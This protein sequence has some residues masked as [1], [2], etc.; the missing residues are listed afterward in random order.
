MARPAAGP[1]FAAMFQSLPSPYMVLDRDLR[2]VAANAAYCAVTERAVE[3]LIGAQ[4][5][6][7]FPNP[8][9][10]G[11]RLRASFE[12]VLRTGKPHSIPLIPYP[13]PLPL[14]RGGGYEM[15]YWSA[16]HTPLLDAEGRTEFIV[17]NTVDVTD[18]QRLK[19]M[20]YG[21]EGEIGPAETTLLQRTREAEAA[22][23]TLREETAGL[24]E[25]FMQAPGFMAVLTGADL[26]FSLVNNAY[27]QLIGHR[28]VIGKPLLSALPEIR[29]QGFDELLRKVMR[30]GEP[31]IGNAVS[32]MLQ[33]TPDQPP[34]ERFLDFI[35][36]PMRGDSG[37]V[38]GVFVQGS[39]VTDRVLGDRQQKLLVDELN[40]R[41]KNTLA[42]VQAIAA[43]TSRNH[44]EPLQFRDLFEARLLALATTHDLLTATH[45]RSAALMDV[46][47]AE[48]RPFAA[49]RYELTGPAVDLTPAQALAMGMIVHELATNAAK[50]GALS[51]EGGCV[52]AGWNVGEDDVLRLDWRE[53]NGP[54]VAPPTRRGFGSRL[55]ERSLRGSLR[56]EARLEFAPAGLICQ[57]E[58]PL[59][60]S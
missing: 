30:T 55:I 14:S 51:I 54:P 38:W 5:F 37:A 26:V 60:E 56:G 17:Q 8:G 59:S 22:N 2:Y 11:D 27:Q 52:R 20:A 25:L 48:L 29:G 43:Q 3:E 4:I 40:H 24:R 18:L 31:F 33:R 41:V 6:D 53:E 49:E 36:Q 46:L 19:A 1:D 39:D 42:T 44:P 9:E 13:I 15:R 7:L 16:V 10:G 57:I 47:Q 23:R 45:W 58:L 28:P 34:Q 35:Y 50:Y 32:V 21:G 12:E